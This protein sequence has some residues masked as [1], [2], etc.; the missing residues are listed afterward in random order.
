MLSDLQTL[1][2]T[3]MFRHLDRDR[4]GVL[5]PADY[6]RM[7]K[8]LLDVLGAQPDAPQAIELS[9]S[10]NTE[11]QELEASVGDH[12]E[13]R[14]TLAVWLAYRDAQ[15]SGPDA[16]AVMID[17]YIETVFTLLDTDED[18]C[19]SHADVSRYLDVYEMRDAEKCEVLAK[20]DPEHR[21]SFTRQEIGELT[22]QYYFSNDENSPGSWLLGRIRGHGADEPRSAQE[23]QSWLVAEISRIVGVPKDEVDVDAPITSYLADSRDALTLAADLQDWL[24]LEIS[25]DIVWDHPTVA[26]LSSHVARNGL[27][28]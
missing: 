22:R 25:A 16:F 7:S 26:A 6:Q 28:V 17:P 23:V 1:K 27:G 5:V 8:R 12:A 4:D 20:L 14:V 3:K 11:W 19:L 15:L 13:T 21:G 9:A 24:G 10:Y 18:G 2:L